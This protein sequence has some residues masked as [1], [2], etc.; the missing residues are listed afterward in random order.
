M[1]ID[2]ELLREA[3]DYALGVEWKGED[4]GARKLYYRDAWLSGHA[5]GLER[6][7]FEANADA[8]KDAAKNASEVWLAEIDALETKLDA[9]E[10]ERD[11]WKRVAGEWMRDYDKLKNKYEPMIA[12]PS[13]A[14]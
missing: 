5:A 12:V 3:E 13:E 11:E 7:R 10:K 9:A 14:P 1:I 4:Y 2:K 8:A 6:G